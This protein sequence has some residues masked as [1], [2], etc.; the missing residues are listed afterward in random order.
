MKSSKKQ[1]FELLAPAGDFECLVAAINAGADAVYF[2]LSNF[3]MRARAKNF[4]FSDLPKIKSLCETKKKKVKRYL[5][6]NTI[7]YDNE[8]TSVEKVIKKV[9]PYVNAV[10]CSDIAIMLLCRKYRLPFHV[11]T[12]CSISNSKTAE[13][14]KN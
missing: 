5:T 6:L 13:F 9:K 8:L 14:Y 12:Q 2:G 1:Q 11:S 3:N 7:I 10:I 4:K